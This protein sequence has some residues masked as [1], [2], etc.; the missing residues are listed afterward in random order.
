MSKFVKKAGKGV[1]DIGS[2]AMK[3]AFGAILGDII[4]EI[5]EETG[6]TNI[7]KEK[8]MSSGFKTIADLGMDPK[9]IQRELIKNALKNEFKL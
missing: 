6:A 5:L 4:K 8:L 9:N 3:K 1:A 2:E 7:A